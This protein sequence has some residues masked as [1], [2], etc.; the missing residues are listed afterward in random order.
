MKNC[1]VYDACG[2]DLSVS[3]DETFGATSGVI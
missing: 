3:V 1:C 2:R